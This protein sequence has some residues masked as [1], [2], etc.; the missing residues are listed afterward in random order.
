MNHDPVILLTN[1]DGI[2]AEGLRALEGVLE[3]LGRIVIV[4]PELEQSASSHTITLDKPLRIKEFARNRTP[5][6]E[7]RPIAFSPRCTA[8]S[9]G[10]R[11]SSCR[12]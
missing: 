3:R 5:S 11:T 7:R 1:D 6:P 9:T 4:A 8:S 2:A 10:N 12:A